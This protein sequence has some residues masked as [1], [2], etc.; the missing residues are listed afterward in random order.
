MNL[1]EST[2]RSS[3]RNTFWIELLTLCAISALILA[4]GIATLG[5]GAA[6]AFAQEA[7]APDA[8]AS[9]THSYSGVVTDT[10]C[11]AK[12]DKANLNAGD[13][14]KLCVKQGAQYALVDGDTLR[15]LKGAI[16][17]LDKYAG[18]RVTVRGT[19]QGNTIL[20]SSIEPAPR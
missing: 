7:P 3:V 5:A 2:E 11:G 1:L 14:T 18:E 13:C 15:P 10:Y 9:G 20:V 4:V 6:L 12:H 19:L 16:P 17:L 8:S